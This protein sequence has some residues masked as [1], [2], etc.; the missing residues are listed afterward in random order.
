MIV[1][2]VIE[3]VIIIVIEVVSKIMYRRLILNIKYRY[4]ISINI[5]Y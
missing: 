3:T 1:Y 5:E 4:W 2:I